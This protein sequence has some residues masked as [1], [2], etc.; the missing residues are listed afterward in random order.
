MARV[1]HFEIPSDEPEKAKEFYSTVF[2][3]K[4]NQWGSEPYWLCSTGAKSKPGIDGAIIKKRGPDHPLVN[5]IGVEDLENTLTLIQ[6]HGGI[7]VVPKMA[8][9]GM[10]WLAYFK[11]LDGNIMGVMEADDRAK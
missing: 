11:D 1:I 7:V 6:Q 3:W 4:L 9:P 2:G 10:G 8:I 5:T